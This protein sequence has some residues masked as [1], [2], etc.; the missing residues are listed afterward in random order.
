MGREM[1]WPMVAERM[2][3]GFRKRGRGG[4]EEGRREEREGGGGGEETVSH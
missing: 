1:A 4:K 2:V 3:N